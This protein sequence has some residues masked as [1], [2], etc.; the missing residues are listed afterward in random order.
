MKPVVAQ[1]VRKKHPVTASLSTETSTNSISIRIAKWCAMVIMALVPFHAFLTV[2]GASFG[3]NY[4]LLRL[5]SAPLL[6]VLIS[7][8]AVWLVRDKTMRDWARQSYVVRVIVVYTL[9]SILMALRG[10]LLGYVSGTALW[11]GL[12]LNLRYLAFFLAMIA[13]VKYYRTMR[14]SSI[15]VVLVSALFVSAFAVLQYTVVPH[16]FL[17]QFGYS[18]S[19]IEPFE[20]I[21][22]NPDFIR[23][24]STLRGAN[25]LGAYMV[26]VI[27]LLAAFWPRLQ[28]KVVW[29]IVGALCVGALLFSFSRSAW[30]GTVVAVACVIG[31]QLRTR[32]QWRRAGLVG[33]GVLAVLAIGFVTLQQN[34]VIQNALYHTDDESTVAVSSN[35]Q[36]ASALSNGAQ[37]VIREPL[38]RG[39][40]SA[41]PASVH[42]ET[43]PARL[44]E[45]YYLQ[46]GQE[47]GWAGL[48]AYLAI[49]IAVGY[50]LWLR[51]SDRL[52]LGLLAS[53]VGLFVVNL[54]SHAW[55]D[56]TLGFIWWGLAG[57]AIGQ[58]LWQK[59][60]KHS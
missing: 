17:A 33:L 54:L 16:D 56:D 10:W 2:W 28:R 60:I 36:R 48:F 34:R 5:W 37:D 9:L 40:G 32:Q 14:A 22:N 29:G 25:P 11:L 3:L 50:E 58:G 46:I 27:A 42:N 13:I 57:L 55:A 45:N 21:N 1:G 12:L 18:S 59:N 53:F 15:R 31:L 43:A 20:T 19:T 44:A 35:D 39:V 51:R 41:G 8:S 7:I 24:A 47:V 52:A 6:L 49:T 23:V 4:T 38:G 26:V 30:L